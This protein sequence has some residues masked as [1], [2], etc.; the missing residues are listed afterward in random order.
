MLKALRIPVAII[1][2]LDI[3]RG[4]V[5]KSGFIPVS[6][7]LGPSTSN[8]YKMELAN[9]LFVSDNLLCHSYALLL[10]LL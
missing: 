2:D 3:K 10:L 7:L 9:S 1:T 5:E 6:S 8:L 4:D